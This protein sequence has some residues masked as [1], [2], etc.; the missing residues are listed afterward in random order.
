[1]CWLIESLQIEASINTTDSLIVQEDIQMQL[2]TGDYLDT[3]YF[4][5]DLPRGD[6]TCVKVS[7][8][9]IPSGK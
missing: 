7:I 2:K 8:V 5:L 4:S 3:C 1:V 6:D 9:D